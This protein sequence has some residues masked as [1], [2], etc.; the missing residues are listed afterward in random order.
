M[1]RCDL[2]E[3]CDCTHDATRRVAWDM[4]TDDPQ[5]I[6]LCDDCTREYDA[7]I[8]SDLGPIDPR[9]IPAKYRLRTLNRFLPKIDWDNVKDVVEDCW[10][11]TASTIQGYGAFRFSGRTGYA[12]RYSYERFYGVE[13]PEKSDNVELLHGCSTRSCCNPAHLW[14]GTRS[15]NLIH[16]VE[17]GGIETGSSISEQERKE[18]REKYENQVETTQRELAVDYDHGQSVISEIVN[19]TYIDAR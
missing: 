17:T 5:I 8:I 18:I 4:V 13:P 14:Q 19:E 11:W 12:H 16:A 9:E 1:T 7:A 3:M 2:H 10:L 15:Q 6:H